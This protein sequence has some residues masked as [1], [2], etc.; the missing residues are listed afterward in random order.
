MSDVYSR[1]QRELAEAKKRKEDS[2]SAGGNSIQ[3]RM[4]SELNAAYEKKRNRMIQDGSYVA[5]SQRANNWIQ[6]VNSFR[7]DVGSIKIDKYKNTNR[8]EILEIAQNLLQFQENEIE[9]LKTFL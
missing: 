1:M 8:K 9:K 4:E 3:A 5:P 6:T 7:K 2:Q